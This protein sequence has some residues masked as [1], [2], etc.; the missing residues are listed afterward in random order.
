MKPR[1]TLILVALFAALVGYLYFFELNKTDAQISATLGTPTARPDPYVFQVNAS[2]AQTFIITDL[3]FPRA[4]KVTRDGDGWKMLEPVAYPG[5]PT[6]LD[7]LASVMSN[8]RA[9]RMITNV[10]NLAAFGLNPAML[11]ARMVMSDT[12]T[13][14][15]VLGNKTPDNRYYYIAYTGDAS[16][17]FLIDTSL[18][19]SLKA[20][21]DTPPFKP[22]ATPT[23][24]PPEEATPAPG[25]EPTGTP[26]P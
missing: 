16:K 7:A 25:A 8:L 20:L 1:N 18:G 15:F 6:K 17:V 21:L 9:T 3:R 14:G 24:K 2:E 11:E 10:T 13:F 26:K 4:I 22:T 5:D 19:D 23:L 12:R